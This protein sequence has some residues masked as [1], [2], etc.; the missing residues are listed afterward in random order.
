MP[1][2]SS[3]K[4]RRTFRKFG[5]SSFRK[6]RKVFRRANG[7][8]PANARPSGNTTV[9]TLNFKL[10]R[11][12]KC[13]VPDRYLTW[14]TIEN[15]G[16][17]GT[18]AGSNTGTWAFAL[19]DIVTPFSKTGAVPTSLPGII[20]GGTSPAFTKNILFN[21]TTG[22]GIYNQYR[23]WSTAVAI[24][25]TPGNAA[26]SV[27]T[28]MVPLTNAAAA[29]VSPEAMAMASNSIAGTST[30]GSS[31]AGSTIMAMWSMPA[32]FG[33]PK[34]V[35]PAFASA[36]VT[37]AT[38]PGLPLFCQVAYRTDNNLILTAGLG[39]RVQIQ[40]HVEFFSRVDT[41]ALT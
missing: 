41:A 14:L 39:I 28:V 23:V 32:L 4:R 22:T 3:G 19:N 16:V 36:I 10:S 5:R 13:P 27:N 6:A 24:T 40:Y 8:A 17:Q 12:V 29:F 31:G 33:V 35:F 18:G 9:S 34:L 11:F 15:Q 1:L 7:I 25:Y 30:F 37:A 26:D 21:V 20:L 38:T 2:R